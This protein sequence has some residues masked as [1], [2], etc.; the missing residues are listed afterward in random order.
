MRQPVDQLSGV[1]PADDLGED[2]QPAHRV[3]GARAPPGAS[4]V[5]VGEELGLVGG[6]VHIGRTVGLT[7]FAGQAQV[8]CFADLARAPAVG[9][10]AVVM[11]VEHFEQQPRP[12][13]RGV[14]LLAGDLIGRAHHLALVGAVLTAPADADAPVRGF[15][16][17]TAV[18]RETE[19][20][21]L[22]VGRG[23]G[24]AP[25]RTSL[26]LSPDS[27]PASL[28]SETASASSPSSRATGRTAVATPR[29]PSTRTT[30]C[31]PRTCRA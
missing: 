18:V 6:H 29:S 2:G 21:V 10:R 11:A 31:T 13:A 24:A 15:G 30:T 26:P 16:E 3:V 5:V 8:E 7:S 19:M 1:Q 9:D 20:Q 4:G 27:S 22:R 14:L 17:R 25:A 28:R 12:A 23:P